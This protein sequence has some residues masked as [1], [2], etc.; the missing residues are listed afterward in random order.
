MIHVIFS[1]LPEKFFPVGA[2]FVYYMFVGEKRF[3]VD[4]GLAFFVPF[5]SKI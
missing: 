5:L 2:V 4:G 3:Q 1:N